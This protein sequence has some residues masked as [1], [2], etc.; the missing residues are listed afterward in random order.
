M[1]DDEVELDIHDSEIG[2]VILPV[3]PEQPPTDEE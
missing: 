1:I 2:V 3:S